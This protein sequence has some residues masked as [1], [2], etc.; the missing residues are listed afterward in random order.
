MIL[1]NH[2]WQK[3][4]E[5]VFERIKTFKSKK[6]EVWL[7]KAR[8][9]DGTPQQ[10]VL[11]AYRDHKRLEKE[12][13]MMTA[14]HRQGLEVPAVYEQQGSYLLMEYI[15]GI[16]LCEAFEKQEC[17]WTEGDHLPESTMEIIGLLTGWLERF[18]QI[19]KELEGK[20]MIMA[21]VNLR[22]FLLTDTVF[23]VDFE[24]CREGRYEE[25]AGKI[26]AYVYTYSPMATPFKKHLVNAFADTF[27]KDLLLEGN[28]IY[29]YM[30]R[31]LKMM[32]RRRKMAIPHFK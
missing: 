21:D 15:D 18:Y 22:N 17:K 1:S 11:K 2:F 16:T 31:E 23:G 27:V 25:D 5:A 26:C 6:N 29:H 14:L 9:S 13:E 19:T 8:K 12:M 32:E 30:D 7:I 28:L 4:D 24:D 3:H 20:S 10:Y